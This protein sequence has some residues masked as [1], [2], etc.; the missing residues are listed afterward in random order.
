M[1]TPLAV[2]T[3]WCAMLTSAL[4]LT[5]LATVAPSA[6]ST[7]SAASL[8]KPRKERGVDAIALPLVSFNSDLGF[9]YG[10]A[11]GAYIYAP[12]HRPYQHGIGV[13]VL[14]TSRGQQSHYLRYDGPQLIGPLRLEARLEYR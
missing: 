13:Q 9:T 6:T 4:L 12:G 1:V 5:T 8:E 3:P 14:F 7:P 10:A 11:G 2:M